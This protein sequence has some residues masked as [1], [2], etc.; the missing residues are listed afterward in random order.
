MELKGVKAAKDFEGKYC[1][2]NGKLKVKRIPRSTKYRL[3]RRL[4]EMGYLEFVEGV[5]KRYRYYKLSSRGKAY[6]ER[7]LK[8]IFR[9]LL[10]ASNLSP[11]ERQLLELTKLSKQIE[12]PLRDFKRISCSYG[13]PPKLLLEALNA[14]VAEKLGNKVVVIKL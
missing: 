1:E 6:K 7:L 9:E 11:Y 2:E 5:D 4:A 8:S 14:R 3:L 12:V 10:E 13:I